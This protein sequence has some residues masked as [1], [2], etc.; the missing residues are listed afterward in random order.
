MGLSSRWE[1][2][3]F[4]DLAGRVYIGTRKSFDSLG[5]GCADPDSW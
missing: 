5:E 2:G 4:S 3:R 1:M